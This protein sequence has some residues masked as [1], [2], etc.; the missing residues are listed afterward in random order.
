MTIQEEVAEKLRHIRE[1]ITD[2][3]YEIQ[4]S[5]YAF[6]EYVKEG[7]T[8]K[9]R[10]QILIMCYMFCPDLYELETWKLDN[11]IDYIIETN[12]DYEIDK[13]YIDRCVELIK[14]VK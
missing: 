10:V 8:Y 7:K 1:R 12:E 3:D 4:T 6:P 2:Y 9:E 5:L 11:I 13:P 14:E